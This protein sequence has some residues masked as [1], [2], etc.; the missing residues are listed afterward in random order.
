MTV[1]SWTKLASYRS[2][3]ETLFGFRFD[4]TSVGR[5][6]ERA[7]S[8]VSA[9]RDSRLLLDRE[10]AHYGLKPIG[11]VEMRVH[12]LD[13]AQAAVPEELG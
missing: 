2:A 10:H 1:K 4:V 6:W 13:H 11:G 7:D 8:G 9:G 3:D 5:E 12:P